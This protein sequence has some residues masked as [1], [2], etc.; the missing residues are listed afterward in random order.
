MCGMFLC[1]KQC[2]RDL[3]AKVETKVG[4]I[5]VISCDVGAPMELSGKES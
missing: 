2:W 5:G 4:G 1:G 3:F